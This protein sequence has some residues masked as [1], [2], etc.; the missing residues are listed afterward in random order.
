L[1][2]KAS[3]TTPELILDFYRDQRPTFSTAED[4]WPVMRMMVR[5]SESWFL[6]NWCKKKWRR[7]E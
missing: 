5:L 3:E 1:Q 6:L 4:G 2:K 7:K